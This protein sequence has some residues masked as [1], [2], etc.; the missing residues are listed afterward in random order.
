MSHA[1]G[2]AAAIIVTAAAAALSI[3]ALAAGRRTGDRRMLYLCGAFACFAVRAILGPL[4]HSWGVIE[5]GTGEVA[6]SAFDLLT[7]GFL[8]APFLHRA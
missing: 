8:V 2:D 6:Q 7:I 4:S 5:H 1:L 3:L